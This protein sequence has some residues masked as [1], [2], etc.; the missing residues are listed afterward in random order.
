[1]TFPLLLLSAILR[2]LDALHEE[3]GEDRYRASVLL[4]RRVKA[5]QGLRA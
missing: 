2:Q 3:Y 1:M 4:R 5:G